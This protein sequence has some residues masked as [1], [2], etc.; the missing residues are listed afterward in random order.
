M[1]TE[2]LVWLLCGTVVPSFLVCWS[3]VWL[4][5][6]LAIRWQLVDRPGYRKVHTA[7]T[8]M[9]G[10]VAIWLGVIVPFAVGQVL[11]WHVAHGGGQSVVERLVPD[12]ARPHLPGIVHQASA[13]WALLGGGTVLMV[14]GLWDDR[15]GLGWQVRLAVQFAVATSCV[16]W[17]GWRL[18]A[19]IALP[20][21]TW[22]LSAIWIVALINSFNM[23]DNMDGLSSGVAAIAAAILAA[24]L[25][26]TPD[27]QT[28]QPQLFVAGFLLVVVGAL[29]GFLPHNRPPARIFMGD[30]GSYFVGFCIAVTTLLATFTEYHGARPHA[31][32]APL[33]VMAVPLYDMTSV[34]WIRLR[35]GRSPF[36]ADKNHF[37]HRLVELGL[38]K[39]QAVL[40][41]YLTTATCAMG[42]LLLQRVDLVGAVIIMAMIASIL[43]L[44]AILESTARRKLGS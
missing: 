32:F 36:E 30:A 29:L 12:F 44:I 13:L 37:S 23:L 18:T 27:P 34:I 25:L 1:G 15:R 31:V 35:A 11:L 7:P 6:R 40:T 38:S 22:L 14:V 9:G 8:P 4:V 20:W 24:A 33:C 41:I 26:L 2:N 42:A 39:G 16:L 19:F 28:R 43:S 3:S 10:G 5:R 17:Q 21:I